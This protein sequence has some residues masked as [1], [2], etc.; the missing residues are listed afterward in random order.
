MALGDAPAVDVFVAGQQGYQTYRIPSLLVSAKGTLLAFAEGRK[1]GRSDSGHIELVLKRSMDNGRTWSGLVVVASDPPNTIGN[2]CAVLD[3]QTGRIWLL[4]TRNLGSDTER[5]IIAGKSKDTRRVLVSFSDDDGVNWSKPIDIT[6]SVKLPKWTW[7]ATGPGVGIQLRSGRLLIPCDHR[8][9]DSSKYRSHVIFSDDHGKNWKLGGVV[10]ED[11]NECQAVEL[12][13]GSVMINMRSYRR[14][15]CR[16]VAISKDG[17]ERWSQIV[18]DATLIEPNCQGS[19]IRFGGDAKHKA[20]VLFCNPASQTKR[21]K[22]TLRVSHDE[23]KSWRDSQLIDEGSSAYSGLAILPDVT[24]G[25][26]YE[27]DNY[28]KIT[29]VRMGMESP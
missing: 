11:V 4:M 19:L 16:A 14:K 10:G 15:G 2:P 8:E 6:A 27:R 5:E 28:S 22:L 7:Y 3:R 23:G 26:L 24:V 12:A 9:L 25:C 29:F 21:E 13:D 20:M 17:G 18:D 1:N